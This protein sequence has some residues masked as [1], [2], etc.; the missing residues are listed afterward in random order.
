MYMPG[1]G[2]LHIDSVDTVGTLLI[3]ALSFF[4]QNQEQKSRCG[5]FWS[6]ISLDPDL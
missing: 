1:Q 2:G 4:L 3:L 5:I 6:S